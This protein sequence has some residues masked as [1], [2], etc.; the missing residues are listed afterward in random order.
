MTKL[1]SREDETVFCV[2]HEEHYV[3]DDD[4]G[5]RPA[6]SEDI[7][8]AMVDRAMAAYERAGGA[9]GGFDERIRAALEAVIVR[10]SRA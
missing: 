4:D 6:T 3:I 8:E 1:P 5:Y 9:M 2:F 7:T 10:E